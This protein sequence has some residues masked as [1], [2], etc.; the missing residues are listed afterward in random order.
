LKPAGDHNRFVIDLTAH[1]HQRIC[2]VL[3]AMPDW[4]PTAVLA[5]EIEAYGRLYSGL[6]AQQRAVYD[7]L[8]QEGVLDAR[9]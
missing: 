8:S 2:A 1:E 6:D 4:D 9:R 7:L 3:D 5:A